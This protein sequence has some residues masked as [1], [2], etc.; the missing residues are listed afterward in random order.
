MAFC[1]TVGQASFQTA[2]AIGPS[3]I[4]RSKRRP[5]G[6]AVC[7]GAVGLAVTSADT[8]AGASVLGGDVGFKAED[9]SKLPCLL[10][11]ATHLGV[12]DDDRWLP[13]QCFEI[14]LGEVLAPVR[15]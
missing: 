14:A 4:E 8:C 12:R 2:R 13:L 6:A 7:A 11:D 15:R 3:T 10:Q 5:D 9:H 1:S